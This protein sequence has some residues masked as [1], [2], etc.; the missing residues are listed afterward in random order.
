MRQRAAMA[1]E[2]AHAD[3]D[4]EE[5]AA[6]S[7]DAAAQETTQTARREVR[8]QPARADVEEEGSSREA[9]RMRRIRAARRKE[10]A[11]DLSKRT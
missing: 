10:L 6:V 7:A 2:A 11:L 8:A 3:R 5:D 4:L 1:R 9:R